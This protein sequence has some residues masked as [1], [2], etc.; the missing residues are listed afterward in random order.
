MKRAHVK[1]EPVEE[2]V[3]VEAEEGGAEVESATIP[4]PKV[5]KRRTYETKHR[6]LLR[7]PRL[8]A[9]ESYPPEKEPPTGQEKETAAS[10]LMGASCVVGKPIHPL[11]HVLADKSST[12]DRTIQAAF[13]ALLNKY[14]PEEVE[15]DDLTRDFLMQFAIRQVTRL[16]GEKWEEECAAP[17]NTCS[18]IPLEVMEAMEHVPA[19]V[20]QRDL[21]L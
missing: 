2:D 20:L 5:Q 11:L 6:S 8:V 1:L 4:K 21:G 17:S 12:R 19:E 3:K 9:H 7:W 15:L 16:L 14:W 13:T 18:G 10:C